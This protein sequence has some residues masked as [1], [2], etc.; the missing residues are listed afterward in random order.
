MEDLRA[1]D[2]LAR[3]R[4]AVVLIALALVL[5]ATSGGLYLWRSAANPI[6]SPSGLRGNAPALLSITSLSD[7]EAWVTARGNS[8]YSSVLMHTTDG[9]VS[10]HQMFSVAGFGSLRFADQRRGVLLSWKPGADPTT[11]TPAVYSTD[12]AGGHWRAVTLP[13]VGAGSVGVP[14]FLDPD[15][16][17]VLVTRAQ[18]PDDQFAQAATLWRTSDGG[19]HWEALIRVDGAH[20][21]SNGVAA[22]DQ[23]LSV[24]F[25]DRDTG[26]IVGQGLAASAVVYLTQD[27]GRDWTP[28]QL[29]AGLPGPAREDLLYA[30]DPA[31]SPNGRGVLPVIDRTIN[32]TWV[33]QTS[34]RGSSWKEPHVAPGT[35][36]DISFVDG[37][38]GWA[39]VGGVAW[40]TTDSGK[41]WLPT[42][43]LPDS[44][45]LAAIGPVSGSMAWAQGVG[46]DSLGANHWA[47]FRTTDAGLHWTQI[48]SPN[49]P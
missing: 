21:F 37:S 13:D 49:L 44:L 45:Q 43:G 42:T 25:Q 20:V 11:S 16:G 15:H 48:S 18:A 22:T 10:W 4:R 30:A 24:S 23:L 32:H 7:R 46:T 19:R 47:M 5:L 28:A 8:A 9:G 39:V 12:D 1:A 27:G 41:S 3:P 6:P 34:D 36:L 29:P 35:A 40:L 26:W 2:S 33:Y 38:V 31:F 17:W 14:F